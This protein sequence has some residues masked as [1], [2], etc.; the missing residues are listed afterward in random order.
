[1]RPR[2][3]RNAFLGFTAL[4]WTGVLS[5]FGTDSFNHVRRHGLDYPLIVHCHAV[6]FVGWLVLFTV[7]VALIRNARPDLH[8]RLGMAAV[9][10][11]AVMLILGPATALFVDAA[12]FSATGRTPEFLAVQ[13]T[14]ILAFAGLTGCG[15]LLREVPA[16]HK[17]LMLMGLIY[18]SDAGFARFINGFAAA[19]LGQSLW[20][21]SVALYFGS[22]LLLL[23]LG[24]Y[25]LT[26]R[27][28]L[29][30][31]YIA[32]V[33]WALALQC[34]ALVLLNNS[35]WKALSLHLIGH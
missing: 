24:A 20:G 9:A 26:T 15:L 14:D 6:A 29:H 35:A 5:G 28:R 18:I 27:G 16:A 21:E 2:A 22:D 17:R 25:D 32:G 30:P 11:A 1:V 10:L 8:R 34:T 33:L 12:R 7:Q 19:P 13:L 3:D 31:A 4:V 23:G